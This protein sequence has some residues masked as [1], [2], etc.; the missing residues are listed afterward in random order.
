MDSMTWDC[1]A[2]LYMTQW[3]DFNQNPLIYVVI[4]AESC[5][6]SKKS[7]YKFFGRYLALLPLAQILMS[8]NESFLLFAD[9]VHI[10]MQA[11]CYSRCK[12]HGN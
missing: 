3:S 10:C 2:L 5:H 4:I 12:G 8:L 6:H 1:L 7:K 11:N 9:S